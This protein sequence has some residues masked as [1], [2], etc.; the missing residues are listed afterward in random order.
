MYWLGPFLR[1]AA[2][3]LRRETLYVHKIHYSLDKLHLIQGQD[4]RASTVEANAICLSVESL[5]CG[6]PPIL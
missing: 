5:P 1:D 6:V 4:Q 3:S 2:Q